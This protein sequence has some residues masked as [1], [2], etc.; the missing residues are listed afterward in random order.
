MKTRNVVELAILRIPEDT[1]GC[2]RDWNFVTLFLFR[3][4]S[5]GFQAV[6]KQVLI[7]SRR[8]CANQRG[9]LMQRHIIRLLKPDKLMKYVVPFEITFLQDRIYHLVQA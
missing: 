3:V 2:G 7:G 5:I 9:S 8:D 4:V 6:H 1:Y